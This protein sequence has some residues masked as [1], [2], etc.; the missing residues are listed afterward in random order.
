MC[1]ARR[2]RAEGARQRCLPH[3]TFEGVTGAPQ[4]RVCIVSNR[5]ELAGSNVVIVRPSGD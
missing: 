1:F 2:I 3:R 4:A 5:A